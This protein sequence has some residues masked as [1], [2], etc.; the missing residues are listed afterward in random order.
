MFSGSMKKHQ[1]AGN[2][3]KPDISSL[4]KLQKIK[5]DAKSLSFPAIYS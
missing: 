2:A 1:P 5:S 4:T 3:H